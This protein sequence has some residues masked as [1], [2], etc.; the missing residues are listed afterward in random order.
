MESVFDV[1]PLRRAPALRTVRLP[2]MDALRVESVVT[3]RRWRRA[4]EDPGPTVGSG[5]PAGEE[6][7]PIAS[8]ALSISGRTR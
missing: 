1:R 8:S 5:V 4:R 6:R 3:N 7:C 2:P